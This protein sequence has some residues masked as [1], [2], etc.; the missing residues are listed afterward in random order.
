[1][2]KHVKLT[3]LTKKVQLIDTLSFTCVVSIGHDTSDYD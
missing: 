2:Y 3:E 1:M